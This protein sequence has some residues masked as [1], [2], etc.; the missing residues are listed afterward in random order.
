VLDVLNRAWK[1]TWG[2]TPIPPT[3]LADDLQGQR[4][5]MLVAV[6]AENDA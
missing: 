6:D 3:A 5:G 1:G 4:A 2:L